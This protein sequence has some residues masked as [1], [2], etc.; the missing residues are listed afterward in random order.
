MGDV[1]L[2]LAMRPVT[3]CFRGLAAALTGKCMG[4][5]MT[6]PL[7][8]RTEADLDYV[9]SVEAL[10]NIVCRLTVAR[11]DAGVG[12]ALRRPPLHPLLPLHQRPR[13]QP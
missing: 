11:V 8:Q 2:A 13:L 3:L 12:R 4:L 7:I 1:A 6:S 5:Q 9:D 10:V